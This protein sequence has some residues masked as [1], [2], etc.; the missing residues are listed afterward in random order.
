M[1]ILQRLWLAHTG[2]TSLNSFVVDASCVINRECNIFDTV[3]VP[4][5]VR[6]HLC[7]RVQG[8]LKSVEDVAV[9]D[10]VDACF[11]V[12]GLKALQ[13]TQNETKLVGREIENLLSKRRIQ[14]PSC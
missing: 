14:S 8:A 9:S 2:C 1:F 13:H 4:R 10:N 3:A 12:A 5:K 7:V 6:V 11:S